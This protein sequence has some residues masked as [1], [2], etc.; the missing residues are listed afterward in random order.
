MLPPD[1]AGNCAGEALSCGGGL[2]RLEGVAAEDF[3]AADFVFYEPPAN[4]AP[5]DGM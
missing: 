3:D 2:I 1:V 4:G 5:I